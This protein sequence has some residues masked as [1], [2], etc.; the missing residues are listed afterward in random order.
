[1][2]PNQEILKLG[3]RVVKYFNARKSFRRTT[4]YWVNGV[5]VSFGVWYYE[6]ERGTQ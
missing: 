6:N 2:A 5:L 4:T 1:M 3:R